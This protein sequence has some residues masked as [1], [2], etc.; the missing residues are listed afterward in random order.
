M[1]SPRRRSTWRRR[2]PPAVRGGGWQQRRRQRLL[3]GVAGAPRGCLL[4]RGREGALNQGRGPPRAL[5]ART[6]RPRGLGRRA[7]SRGGPGATGNDDG[8]PWPGRGR[9]RRERGSPSRSGLLGSRGGRRRNRR[10]AGSR[11]RLYRSSTGSGGGWLCCRRRRCLPC[12]CRGR[13]RRPPLLRACARRRD[14]TERP[15]HLRG[16]GRVS[17]E[18]G[19]GR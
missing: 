2:A 12:C 17:G 15:V 13:R 5:L 7:G 8:H 6:L 10:G 9:R 4:C 11:W 3:R 1:R 19:G 16:C 14:G 18:G